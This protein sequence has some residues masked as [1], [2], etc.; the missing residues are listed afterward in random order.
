M[1]LRMWEQS[2]KNIYNQS[3]W[4]PAILDMSALVHCVNMPIE[5]GQAYAQNWQ[6][7]S[8]FVIRDDVPAYIAAHLDC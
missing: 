6:Y 2:Y 4:H 3:T 7:A 1:M 8:Q 5:A